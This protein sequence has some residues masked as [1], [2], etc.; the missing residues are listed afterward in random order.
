MH[1]RTSEYGINLIKHFEKFVSHPYKCPAGYYTIGYG[2]RINSINE[3]SFLNEYEATVLL[4]KDLFEVEK[5]ITRNIIS[6]NDNQFD[7][8]VS[9]TFNVGQA[10]LQRSTLKQKINFYAEDYEI[11]I[12]FMRWTHI[13]GTKIKGLIKRREVEAQLFLS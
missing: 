5:S 3:Y 4:K 10:A 7:A 2:H 1:K 11:Y 9:F 12:E 6:L 13:R 8:L